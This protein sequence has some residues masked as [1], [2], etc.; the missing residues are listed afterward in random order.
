MFSLSFIELAIFVVLLTVGVVSLFLTDGWVSRSWTRYW[1]VAA[2][3]FAVASLVTQAD[4][5]TTLIVAA[6]CM[7]SFLLG[8]LLP[9]DRSISI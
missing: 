9:R 4:L 2:G 6:M 1:L 7:G 8:T 3:S 5:F